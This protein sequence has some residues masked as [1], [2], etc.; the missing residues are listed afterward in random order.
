MANILS[1]QYENICSV[2]REK[3]DSK[4]FEE[5]LM[6]DSDLEGNCLPR[7]VDITIGYE[8]I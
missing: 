5:F 2:P 4:S 1:E 7:M 3:I 6:D 8:E